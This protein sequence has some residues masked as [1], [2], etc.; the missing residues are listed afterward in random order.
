MA[1]RYSTFL[2]LYPTG[3]TSEVG[4]IYVA[5][6]FIKV[7]ILTMQKS[8]TSFANAYVSVE[9]YTYETELSD[10]YNNFKLLLHVYIK[11]KLS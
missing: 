2:L 10:I 11:M 1:C 3:I 8:K 7:T 9:L 4:L 6:P 5:L